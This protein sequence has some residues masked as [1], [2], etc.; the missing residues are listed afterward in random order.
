MR[1]GS[2]LGRDLHLAHT[3]RAGVIHGHQIVRHADPP[4]RAEEAAPDRG[5]NL[6][7]SLERHDLG[8]VVAGPLDDQGHVADARPQDLL[9]TRG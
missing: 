1:P 2:A 3:E 6:L 8:F 4:E 9:G 5:S 7:G